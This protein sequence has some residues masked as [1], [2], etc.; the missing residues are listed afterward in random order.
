MKLKNEVKVG[1]LA[2]VA[3]ALLIIG[4]SFLKGNDVFS[5]DR[6]YYAIY[7]RVDGLTVSK[8]ILVN[9]YQIG[10]VSGMELQE[11]G[12]IRT[13]LKVSD[14]YA[15]PSNTIAKIVSTDLLGGKAIVF[16][17][18]DSPIYAQDGHQLEAGSEKNIMEQVE[19]I[20]KKA[21]DIAAVLDSVLSSINN[22]I[23]E[24]F[25]RDFN[26]SIHS[27]ANSLKNIEGI[28]GQLDELVGRERVRVSDI[29]ANVA[30]ITENLK[31]NNEQITGMLANL[32][33]ITDQ[34]ARANV[35]NTVESANQAVAD[36]QAIVDRINQGE[37]SI[38]MLINDTSL[39]EN[40]QNASKNL[41]ELMI[42]IKEH[43]G[44]YVHFSIFGR[45]D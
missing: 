13:E 37:G 14:K 1:L 40:L 8:P 27:I 11:D 39:Y 45:K 4:Y 30:S 16:E 29:M 25:Q 23:N 32:N 36:F 33:T 19:P 34:V 21:Q 35:A 26:R 28:T 10:R 15:V 6:T 44:R 22:T 2:I 38:G 17:L 24:D 5:T 9:G 41:D 12:R 18:G 43:P 3:L 31:N 7:D 20:Q 42:D